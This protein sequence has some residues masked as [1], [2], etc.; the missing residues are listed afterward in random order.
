MLTSLLIAVGV[1]YSATRYALQRIR[2]SPWIRTRT[3]Q[4]GPR[5]VMSR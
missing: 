5:R 1:G 4:T 2:G 3:R